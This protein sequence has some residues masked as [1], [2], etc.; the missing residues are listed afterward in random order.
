MATPSLLET[1]CPFLDGS[2]P[3]C[4]SDDSAEIM[5]MF[6]F[7][8]ITN[9]HLAFNFAALDAVFLADC[10]ICAVNLKTM[11]CEYACNP[12]KSNFSKQISL[13]YFKNLT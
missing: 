4:C 6:I 10:P 2:V 12:E 13:F 8:I 3:V 11:W 9:F 1:P 5:C 7:L